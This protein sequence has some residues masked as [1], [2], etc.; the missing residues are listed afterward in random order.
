MVK[1]S[2]E[3][4]DGVLS[5]S[6]PVHLIKTAE[7]KSKNGNQWLPLQ[8]YVTISKHFFLKGKGIRFQGTLWDC[9]S[10]MQQLFYHVRLISFFSPVF[11]H[12]T[13]AILGL[14]RHLSV[15][16]LLIVTMLH[17]PFFHLYFTTILQWK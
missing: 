4:N 9:N 1:F 8:T 16:S 13:V 3:V 11:V 17:K 12:G 14:C 5:T 2:L 7:L 15:H 6:L 10:A